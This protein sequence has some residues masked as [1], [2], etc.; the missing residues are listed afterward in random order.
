MPSEQFPISDPLLM[1]IFFD[2]FRKQ[3]T[4]NE[5]D[6]PAESDEKFNFSAAEIHDTQDIFVLL[7]Y[8][9]D[10]LSFPKQATEFAELISDFEYLFSRT[11]RTTVA[12]F[13]DLAAEI[14]DSM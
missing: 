2:E 4:I 11:H 6:T 12:D 3:I 1:N 10:K 9:A 13:Y 5:T 14:L 8:L 7:S